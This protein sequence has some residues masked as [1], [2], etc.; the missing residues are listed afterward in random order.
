MASGSAS[1]DC[2]LRDCGKPCAWFGWRGWLFCAGCRCRCAGVGGWG[3][4]NLWWDCSTFALF[5]SAVSGDQREVA[6]CCL[7]QLWCMWVLT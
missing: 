2:Y 5:I 1:E 3:R 6:F 4:V 7:H